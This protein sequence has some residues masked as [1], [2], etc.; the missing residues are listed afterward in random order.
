M[1]ASWMYMVHLF[2]KGILFSLIDLLI[3]NYLRFPMINF[4]KLSDCH[5]FNTKN[6]KYILKDPMYI[7]KVGRN[8]IKQKG[9]QF[10]NGTANNL[11]EISDF[12]SFKKA[13]K[14]TII[15]YKNT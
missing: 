14:Y 6:S 7:S 5:D 15:P 9:I 2:Y 10:W 3:I 12:K 11:K 4:L 8:S 13:F 1:P